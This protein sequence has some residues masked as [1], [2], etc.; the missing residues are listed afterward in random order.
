MI[1]VCSLGS[2]TSGPRV[3]VLSAKKYAESV[4]MTPEGRAYS[5]AYGP[6]AGGVSGG[7]DNHS[8]KIIASRSG[9][10]AN[11]NVL[12]DAAYST[13]GS[14]HTPSTDTSRVLELTISTVEPSIAVKVKFSVTPSGVIGFILTTFA[15]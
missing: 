15:P 8:M 4:L 11:A 2:L 1:S 12:P 3:S 9:G 14:C 6:G 7:G 5:I 10:S 13:T